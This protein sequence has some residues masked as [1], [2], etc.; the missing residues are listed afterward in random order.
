MLRDPAGGD[1]LE[2]GVTSH[3]QIFREVQPCQQEGPLR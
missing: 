2:Q 1:G 3:V